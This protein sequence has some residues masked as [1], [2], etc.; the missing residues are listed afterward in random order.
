M[1]AWNR[2]DEAEDCDAAARR[3][4]LVVLAMQVSPRN[5]FTSIFVARESTTSL[6]SG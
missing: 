3:H 5:M 4:F 2:Y 1:N 6:I